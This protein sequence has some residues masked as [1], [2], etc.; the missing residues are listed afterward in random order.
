MTSTFPLTWCDEAILH[1]EGASDPWNIQMEFGGDGRLDLSRLEAAVQKA[2]DAHPIARSRLVLGGAQDTSDHWEVVDD[3]RPMAI[4]VVE[5]PDEE[6]LR[7]ARTQFYS[8][9]FP[10][11]DAPVFRAQ[12]ARKPDGDLLMVNA[13]HA[14]VDGIGMLRLLESIAL[15]YRGEAEP[16]PA[17]PLAE[18]REFKQLMRPKTA[19][20][21]VSRAL[22]GGRKL[23]D[24]AIAP[25]RVAPDRGAPRDGSGFAHRQIGPE[26]SS[27]L[28]A[29][30]PEGTTINDMLLGAVGLTIEEWNRDH[31]QAA[32]KV[33]I[34]MPVNVRPA[35]WASDVVSNLFSYVSIS[36]FARNRGDLPSA[37]LAVAEQT[38]PIRR[39]AR[40]HGTQD[41]L[42]LIAPLPLGVKRVMPA[43]LTLTGNRFVDSAVVSNLGRP[44][45]LASFTQNA[46]SEFY[47]TPPYWSAAAISVGA[48]TA[49]KTL[50]IGLR[51]RLDTLD[52][53]AGERLADLLVA[54]LTT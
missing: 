17:I 10:I 47:F 45:R 49:G 4:S 31:G 43:L 44:K 36:T 40:A 20:E 14:A 25:A 54:K 41:L 37:A 19:N 6:S 53:A 30:R 29:R 8:A 12:V 18:A 32:D 15:A 22:E 27:A 46:P 9:P 33:M 11:A 34:F 24:A 51:Y 38:A 16:P 3:L 35:E 7:R 50:Q 52:E 42:R 26:Q 1:L 48:I 23:R 5:C 28:N 39:A 2:C 13:A 21:L